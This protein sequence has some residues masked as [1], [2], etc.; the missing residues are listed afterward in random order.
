MKIKVEQPKSWQRVLEVEV[1]PGELEPEI[2][3]GYQRFQR[4]FQ[5]DGFR[6]GRVPLALIKKKFG[7]GLENSFVEESIPDL[8]A[9]A[10]KKKK[11]K[12]VNQPRIDSVDHSPGSPLRFRAVFEVEPEIDL[13]PY[14]ELEVVKET[15]E[16]SEKDVEEELENLREAAAVITPSTE[17][18]ARGDIIVADLQELDPAGLPLVGRKWENVTLEIGKGVFGPDLDREIIGTKEG[19]E[20]KVTLPPPPDAKEG[21][22]GQHLLLKINEV[23]TKELP[24][25]DDDFARQVGEDYQSMADLKEVVKR[26][27]KDRTEALARQRFH[28]RLAGQVVAQNRVEVPESMVKNYLD[29][30]VEKARN[31]EGK[32]I[33]EQA[34]RESYRDQTVWNLK[35]YLTRHRIAEVEGL[36]VLKDAIE[37]EI[38]RLSKQSGQDLKKIRAKYRDEDALSNL[39][40][41]ILE[42]NV[43]D[44]LETKVKIKVEKTPYRILK[45]EPGRIL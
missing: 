18:A 14:Q 41:D 15:I 21:Q 30:V 32:P 20:R 26:G 43:L 25:L 13:G 6:R 28:R 37:G 5:L 45:G 1:P 9:R 42:K 29:M 33:D 31:R 19:E 8:F 39:K 24:D 11:L 23:K 2:E 27:L 34:L 38:R 22:Q 16:V 10:T 4:T 35:W 36:K 40:E 3:K 12:P 44:F 7:R 17:P